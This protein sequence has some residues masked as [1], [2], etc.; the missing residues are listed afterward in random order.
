MNPIK[1]TAYPP[2]PPI[3]A[4][5]TPYQL[6]REAEAGLKKDEN[7]PVVV[8][9]TAY[10][11]KREAEAEEKKKERNPFLVLLVSFMALIAVITGVIFCFGD[12]KPA[13]PA[14]A[15]IP[16]SSQQPAHFEQPQRPPVHQKHHAHR[17]HDEQADAQA[18]A[19]KTHA[20]QEPY[21]KRNARGEF[22]RNMDL[23]TDHGR[24]P[25]VIEMMKIEP[26]KMNVE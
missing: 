24:A 26:V 11:I 4:R 12:T 25:S 15:P 19:T 8:R 7:Q 23:L 10:Q 1:E 9:K 17:A 18:V 3:V 20:P 2:I 6:R 13:A 14:P 16:L 21:Y 5:K 22:Q